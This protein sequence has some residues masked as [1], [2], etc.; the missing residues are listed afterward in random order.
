MNHGNGKSQH[1]KIGYNVDDGHEQIQGPQALTISVR[2][3]VARARD[4]DGDS[5]R[6]AKH[7]RCDS[8][9]GYTHPFTGVDAV[10]QN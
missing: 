5:K 3:G 4:H 7:N 10:I 6:I 8:V 9:N 2:E 1:Q